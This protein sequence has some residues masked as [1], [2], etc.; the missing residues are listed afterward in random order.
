MP[1]SSNL[2]ESYTAG[3]VYLFENISSRG[4]FITNSSLVAKEKT[5][6]TFKA[7]QG[8]KKTRS[9][10]NLDSFLKSLN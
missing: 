5:Y 8:F 9:I 6:C 2:N 10:K 3:T 7:L 4:N 1:M